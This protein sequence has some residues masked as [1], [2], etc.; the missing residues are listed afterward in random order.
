[1]VHPFEREQ[2]SPQYIEYGEH[3]DVFQKGLDPVARSVYEQ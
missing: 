3:V 2:T 1:M